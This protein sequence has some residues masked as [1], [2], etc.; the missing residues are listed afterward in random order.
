MTLLVSGANGYVGR[1]VCAA[2]RAAGR[3]YVAAVRDLDRLPPDRRSGAVAVGE[4]GPDTDWRAALDGADT[5]LHLASPPLAEADLAV[6]QATAERVIVEG[7]RALLGQARDMGVRRFVY[8]SSIKVMGETSG[9]RAFLES[10]PPNPQ[11][12]YARAKLAAERLVADAYG[13]EAL[14]LRSPAIYGRAS[15]GNVRQMI[16]LLRRAPSVLPLG[17]EGNRRSFIHRDN[18]VAALLHCLDAR[19][20]LGGVYHVSDGEQLSTGA[21]VRR[22]LRALNRSVL[23]VPTPGPVLAALA[24]LRLGPDGARRL[25]DSYAID[26]SAFRRVMD[27]NPPL[28]G[29][30]AMADAVA[31]GPDPLLGGRS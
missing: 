21:L 5:V 10:D 15:G 3:G 9:E 22:V 23:V 8:V 20:G 6:R 26:D 24:R 19:S 31:P 7:T 13:R 18:L 27:W 29:E 30:A 25:V 11:D 28:A 1:A 14:V 2:C 16:E 17:Y 4:H 12:A